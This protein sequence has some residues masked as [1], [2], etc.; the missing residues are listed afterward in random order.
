MPGKMLHLRLSDIAY[1][2]SSGL[3]EE[4]GFQSLQEYFR[5]ALRMMNEE[6]KKR[7]ALALLEK[8]FGRGKGKQ[9]K[10][11]TKEERR[12]LFLEFEK[13]DKSDIFRKAGLD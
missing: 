8:N 12:R 1:R 10:R 7:K 3:A 13:E 9:V 2:D 6:Y 4:F 11:L 5:N